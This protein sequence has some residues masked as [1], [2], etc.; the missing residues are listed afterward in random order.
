MVVHMSRLKILF[1][2]VKQEFVFFFLL[3]FLF[4]MELFSNK[5]NMLAQFHGTVHSNQKLLFT[6]INTVVKNNSKTYANKLYR[7]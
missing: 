5:N 6:F 4:F 2:R 3:N 7:Y 1:V